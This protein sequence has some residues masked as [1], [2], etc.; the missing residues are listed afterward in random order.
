[1]SKFLDYG[2]FQSEFKAKNSTESAFL[3]IAVELR[4]SADS[5]QVSILVLDISAA[6]DTLNHFI[7]ANRLQSFV[8]IDGAALIWFIFSFQVKQDSDTSSIYYFNHGVPQTLA[9]GPIL[10]RVYIL[11]L[12][13]LFSSLGPSFHCHADDTQL[14]IPCTSINYLHNIEFLQNL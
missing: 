14:Y 3:H 2:T 6:F 8:G 5:G 12:L 13:V 7:L 10:F 9:L 4:C 1:M 11:L